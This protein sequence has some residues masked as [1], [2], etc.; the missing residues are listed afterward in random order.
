MRR[1]LISGWFLMETGKCHPALP[2]PPIWIFGAI[3][4]SQRLAVSGNTP[5][6]TAKQM[7]QMRW[8]SVW[9]WVFFGP[10]SLGWQSRIHTARWIYE[11]IQIQN[12]NP[13]QTASAERRASSTFP[14]PAVYA[15]SM[16]TTT[17]LMDGWRWPARWAVRRLGCHR[18]SLPFFDFWMRRHLSCWARFR[19]EFGIHRFAN[20]GSQTTGNYWLGGNLAEQKLWFC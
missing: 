16:A 19:P 4:P 8:M 12:P 1:R 13:K 3:A 9:G 14:L 15:K 20:Y 10:G 6:M 2:I 7:T 18:I 11:C 5:A 17:P